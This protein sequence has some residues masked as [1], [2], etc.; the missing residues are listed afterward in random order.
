MNPKHGMKKDWSDTI[1]RPFEVKADSLRVE[2]KADGSRV[3]RFEGYLSVFGNEDS[4]DDIVEPGSFKRTIAQRKGRFPLA[5]FHDIYAPIGIFLGKEDA[6]GL[7][8][9]AFINLDIQLGAEV[10][11]GMKFEVEEIGG[12]AAYITELSIGYNVIDSETDEEGRRHLKEIALREGSLLTMYCASNPEAVVTVKAN[13]E[14][15]AP[16]D[17]KALREVRERFEK[18]ADEATDLL[19]S[20]SVT[21]DAKPSEELSARIAALKAL[22]PEDEDEDDASVEV[23]TAGLDAILETARA[24][25]AE[26]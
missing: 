6:L 13:M 14:H 4:Y 5:W 1:T 2:T 3:G 10:Y 24:T 7:Y 15:I 12:D 25:L 11:S 18:A 20:V 19:A 26:D 8:I 17:A 9:E 23:D 21:E 16:E 22:I